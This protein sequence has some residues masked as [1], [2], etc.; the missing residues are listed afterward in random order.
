[1]D[2][3]FVVAMARNRAIGRDNAIPWHISE[4]LKHFKRLTLGKPVLMGRRTFESIGRPLPQRLNIVLSRDPN[5]H[6]E[7]TVHAPTLDEALRLAEEAS[8]G[9]EAM[10]IGG[11]VIYEMALPRTR[12]IYLTE[13]ELDPDADTFFPPLESREWQEISRERR[14]GNP[15]FSF[16]TLERRIAA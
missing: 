1:M 8:L 13:V 2:I 16:V 4:D 12:R 7:G 5:F 11:A 15:S 9:N 6:A 14:A 3:A 10:V